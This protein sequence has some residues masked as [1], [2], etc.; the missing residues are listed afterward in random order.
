MFLIDE[1]AGNTRVEF[2]QLAVVI[3]LRRE[4]PRTD[5]RSVHHH[6]HER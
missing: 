2:K 3:E 4:A 6:R 1:N 5:Q